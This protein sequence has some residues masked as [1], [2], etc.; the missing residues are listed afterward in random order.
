MAK[1]THVSGTSKAMALTRRLF[2][3]VG[4]IGFLTGCEV[5]NTFFTNPNASSELDQELEAVLVDASGGAGMEYFRLPGSTELSK[6]PQDPNN[7]L[8]PAKVELGRL[9]YHE[10]ALAT[11]PRHADMAGTYSCAAC[12]SAQAGFQAG[13]IQG[14]SEGGMG[15]GARGEGRVNNPDYAPEDLDVQ[16]IRTPASMNTA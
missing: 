3:V 15:Y 7:P 16:P 6:I 5:S 13:R 8:T 14:I 1:H 12:H 11:Q 10:T 2:V 4:L 9:L